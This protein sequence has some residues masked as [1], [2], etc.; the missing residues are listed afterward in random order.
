M[1]GNSLSVTQTGLQGVETAMQAVSDNLSNA[2]TT[3][4]QAESVEFAT[5]LGEFVAGSPLGGGVTVEGINRDFSQGAIVQ[6]NSP[7]DLAIQ[8]NGFFVMQD[9]S[10]NTTFSR[11][12]QFVIGAGGTLTGFNGSQVMGFPVSAAGVPTGVLG[13]IVVPQGLLAPTASTK[14]TLSGNLDATSAVLSGAINPADPTTYNTSV[15]VQVFDSLGNS[16]VLTYY[17]QN[18]G[19]S[20]GPPPNEQWNWLAT[21]DG[22]ATGLAG[23]T[24]SFGFDTAG[25]LVIGGT[26]ATPLTAAIT[27][28]ANL[29]LNLD[30]TALT[31]F[32]GSTAATG[33][34]D[35]NPVGRPLGVQVDDKG[36]VSVAYSN[37][38]TVKIAQVAVATFPSTQGLAL[39]NG[40]VYMQTTASGQPTIATAGA[41]AAGTIRPSSLENSNVDTTSQLISLVVLQRSFQANA[42]ALQTEDNILGTVIQLQTT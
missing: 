7:T 19:P 36:I 10:G 25:Q 30:F 32:A 38:S 3:G 20:V 22:S 26:P 8:G 35:G 17:F 31:Q 41:G 21:L 12:G 24:G 42:K 14:T 1:A 27:G 2:Q 29:S 39:S 23:N 18:T 37:G 33:A 28:A 6:S 9:A 13:P 40:G 15:S 16:H 34:A 4:F 5:L 11:N